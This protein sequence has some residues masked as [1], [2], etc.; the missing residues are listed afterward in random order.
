LE[1][2]H[3]ILYSILIPVYNVESYLKECLDSVLNQ[4]YKNF[5]VILIDDGSTDSSGKICDEYKL[6]D[7]RI[8]VFHQTNK[9]PLATRC[10][11]LR[12]ASG[13]YCLFLDSDD[14]WDKD[15]LETIN[16]AT[17]TSQCDM[18]I[19]RYKRVSESGIFI[20]NS[21][22]LFKDKSVINK[23][24]LYKYI[25]NSSN[26][27][28]LWTKAVK[29]TIIDIDNDY[30]NYSSIKHSEDLLQSLVL[31]YRA[32]TI[33]Y[34]DK[35]LYNYRIRKGSITQQVSKNFI[36]DTSIVRGVL[37][38]YLKKLGYDNEGTLGE[39][40]RHY[41]NNILNYFYI[42]IYADMPLKDKHIAILSA[43]NQ[44]L[45]MDSLKYIDAKRLSCPKRILYYLVYNDNRRLLLHYIRFV[46]YVHRIRIGQN[47]AH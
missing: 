2:I 12:R 27:N 28:S 21:V 7:N 24:V 23:D 16:E 34:V 6:L 19:Y 26:L 36:S 37:L 30:S 39:F 32:E 29:R 10:E 5:E 35:P 43:R 18:V 42:I 45:Y 9:G 47:N 3:I 15:L 22:S 8:K 44:M 20:S 11:A 46:Y 41:I 40:Y 38:E 31:F 4:T 17:M 14:F 25:I 33:V 1:E 13:D